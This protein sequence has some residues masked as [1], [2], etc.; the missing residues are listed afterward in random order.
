MDV[1]ELKRGARM[2][3]GLGD[4]RVEVI[5]RSMLPPERLV[6]FEREAELLAREMARP[7]GDGIVIPNAYLR[8]LARKR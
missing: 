5:L 1:E 4:Y 2:V 7:E 8:V 6:E 3:W